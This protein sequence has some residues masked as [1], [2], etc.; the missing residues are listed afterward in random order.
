MKVGHK[1]WYR[2]LLS[3]FCSGV[4]HSIHSRS[5]HDIIHLNCNVEVWTQETI[6]SF[7][8]HNAMIMDMPVKVA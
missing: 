3:S 2:G 8:N 7:Y 5:L 6:S 1:K 4:T